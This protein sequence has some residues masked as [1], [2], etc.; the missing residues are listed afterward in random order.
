MTWKHERIGVMDKGGGKEITDRQS[1]SLPTLRFLPEDRGRSTRRRPTLGKEGGHPGN[2]A[3]KY[4]STTNQCLR[5]DRACFRKNVL[6]NGYNI[7]GLE[8]W[9]TGTMELSWRKRPTEKR[10]RVRLA[11]A[12][13]GPAFVGLW[14]AG[15]LLTR[16]R[17][18]R[19]RAGAGVQGVTL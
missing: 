10:R 16:M 7:R 17:Q 5:G 8:Y 12:V 2:E 15:S 14:P 11:A 6:Y 9:K 4:N 3:Y 19:A 13:Q 18:K 1:R